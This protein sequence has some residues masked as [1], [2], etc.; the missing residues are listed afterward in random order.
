MMPDARVTISPATQ[1]DVPVLLKLIRGL[2]DYEKLSHQC[3]ATEEGLRETL[4]GERRLNGNAR[5]HATT[6]T[7]SNAI[8]ILNQLI[9]SATGRPARSRAVD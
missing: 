6:N 1:A 3:V 2:A 5:A 9:A 7:M 4:F 8:R